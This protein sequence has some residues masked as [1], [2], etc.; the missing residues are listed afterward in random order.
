M[1]IVY[2]TH[3]FFPRH[4]GGVEVY[5]LGLASAAIRAGHEAAVVTYVE[6][7][8]GDTGDFGIVHTRYQ[9][10]AVAEIHYNLSVAPDR[11]R[12]EYDNPVVKRLVSEELRRTRPDIVHATHAMK[13]SGSALAAAYELGI[14]V[15]VTLCDYWFLCPRHT[16]L[17]GRGLCAGPAHPLACARCLHEIHGALAGVDFDRPDAELHPAL[18]RVLEAGSAAAA[19]TSRELAFLALRQPTLISLL[20][21]AR[22]VIALSCFQKKLLAGRGIDPARIEVIAHGVD[23][24][25]LVRRTPQRR[26]PLRLLFVGSLVEH[27]G[28]HVLLAAMKQAPELGLELRAYGGVDRDRS[29]VRE[30]LA[31]AGDDPRVTFKGTFDTAAFGAVLQ[32]GDLL[33]MPA[34]WYENAPLVVKAAQYTGMPVMASRIG[35]LEEMVRHGADGWLVPPGDVAAWTEALRAACDGPACRPEPKD[36]KSL[37]ENSREILEIYCSV[38]AGG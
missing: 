12:Y 33:V 19:A 6:S 11:L 29:Y 17:T 34:L 31:L 4:V 10:L 22:R 1:K 36:L 24:D 38:C 9:G 18:Y 20:E 7:P 35:S 14:P 30:L 32:Q 21:R 5:T 27:K 26:G 13:L 37:A 16:L 8:S 3:Q 28:L 15:V 25:G 23:T 2:L